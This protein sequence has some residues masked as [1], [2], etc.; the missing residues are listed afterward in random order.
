MVLE[1]VMESLFAVVD[2]FFVSKLGASAVATVGLTES[3]LALIYTVAMGLS[4]GVT[5]MVS[6]RTGEREPDRA[7]VTAVQA[8]ALGVIV[9]GLLGGPGAF[10]AGDLL[11]I[12]GA[13]PDVVTQGSMFTRIML[14]GNVVIMLIFL[15]N[16]IFRGAGD[17]AIAMRVLWLSN[18][19]NI[20]LDPI[21][22][23]GLG[24]V[25]AL[26]VT[27][28]AVATTIGRGTGVLFQFYALARRSERVKVTRRHLQLSPTTMLR[29]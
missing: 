3:M 12:M 8:I 23:F 26:G 4:I 5:A 18:G 9:A 2:V 1:M 15:I 22:I 16:A 20:I 29:M 25:P 13:T 28:A 11:R 21:F 14:G 24:P 17:A 27:G 6:R 19:F 10:F 7:A